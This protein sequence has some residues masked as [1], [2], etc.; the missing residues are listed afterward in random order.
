VSP[1]LEAVQPRR[2]PEASIARDAAMF[3]WQRIKISPLLLEKWIPEP[4]IA[5]SECSALVAQG[6]WSSNSESCVAAFFD[7][8]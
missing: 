6:V 1:N 5:C 4:K 7:E 8:D 3:Q 2:A